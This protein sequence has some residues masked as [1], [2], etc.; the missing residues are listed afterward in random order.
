MASSRDRLSPGQEHALHELGQRMIEVGTEKSRRVQPE[1]LAV[2]ER[3]GLVQKRCGGFTQPLYF[4]MLSEEGWRRY[5]R[6]LEEEAKE[7][8][9]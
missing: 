4:W 9:R 2:M 7:A 6:M 3:R 1:T 5:E 8:Q